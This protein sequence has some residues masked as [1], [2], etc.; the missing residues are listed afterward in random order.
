MLI[1]NTT[2][3]HT[4][5]HTHT[6]R[7][8][9]RPGERWR[10]GAWCSHPQSLSSTFLS[11]QPPPALQIYSV[12]LR[13]VHS[14]IFVVVICSPPRIEQGLSWTCID[15]STKETST[16]I[17]NGGR[18]YRSHA[19]SATRYIDI[20]HQQGVQ[21]Y[22]HTANILGEKEKK[23]A[24]KFEEMAKHAESMLFREYHIRVWFCSTIRTLDRAVYI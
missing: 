7:A 3:T 22:A 23:K 16:N 24:F 20:I 10:T 4:H 6:P 9:C 18:A 17:D 8:H 14:K 2:H 11:R 5:T 19:K 13:Y 21:V 12:D 15:R 1:C